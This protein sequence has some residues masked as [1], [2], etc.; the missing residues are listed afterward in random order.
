MLPLL[1]A[2]VHWG[3]VQ[4]LDP[5]A[6]TAWGFGLI[7]YRKT[8]SLSVQSSTLNSCWQSPA[9]LTS[10][11]RSELK[12]AEAV[13]ALPLISTSSGSLFP[14][15]HICRQIS[16]H[17]HPSCSD[18]QSAVAFIYALKKKAFREII[19]S[20]SWLKTNHPLLCD[21]KGLRRHLFTSFLLVTSPPQQ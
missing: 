19:Y 15:S 17:L 12:P 14:L 18:N 1:P 7:K 8:W 3:C 13:G 6:R 20:L 21:W 9:L 2:T 5:P 16:E 10:S 11:Y 4:V